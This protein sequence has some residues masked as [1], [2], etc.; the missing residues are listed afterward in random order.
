MK[1][2]RGF[3]CP[4]AN[5]SNTT[6]Q[7][8]NYDTTPCSCGRRLYPLDEG[9]VMQNEQGLRHGSKWV[10]RKEHFNRLPEASEYRRKKRSDRK[11]LKR[12]QRHDPRCTSPS[13]CDDTIDATLK[14]LALEGDGCSFQQALQIFYCCVTPL[15]PLLDNGCWDEFERAA[16]KLL[17]EASR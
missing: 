16:E 14:E 15:H 2:S 11:R 9:S 1:T 3:E 12:Q 17:D 6:R 10:K 7:R 8:I 4:Q 5:Q 13:S